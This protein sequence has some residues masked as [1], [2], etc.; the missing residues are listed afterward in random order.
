MKPR[1]AKIAL[2]GLAVFFL[3]AATIGCKN[4][5]SSCK[6]GCNEP[7]FPCMKRALVFGTTPGGETSKDR[8]RDIWLLW[9]GCESDKAVCQANCGRAISAQ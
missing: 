1:I 8:Q 3:S 5:A 7:Y 2:T 6:R 9:L 4:D